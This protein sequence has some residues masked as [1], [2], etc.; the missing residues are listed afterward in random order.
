MPLPR[1]IY[2]ITKPTCICQV[3]QA[4]DFDGTNR[5]YRFVSKDEAFVLQEQMFAEGKSNIKPEDYQKK[6]E[7][8]VKICEFHDG[9]TES[10]ELYD[11]LFRE[12]TQ[13]GIV[14]R[15]LEDNG[16]LYEPKEYFVEIEGQPGKFE[17]AGF[18]REQVEINF[19]G[20]NA[21]RVIALNYLD[22]EIPAQKKAHIKTDIESRTLAKGMSVAAIKFPDE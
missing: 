10:Q 8:G 19:N 1:E 22:S 18:L 20:K 13:L 5:T 7:N 2:I 14:L 11:T 4:C 6:M 17:S 9:M 15:S 12:A 21:G 3:F 16:I